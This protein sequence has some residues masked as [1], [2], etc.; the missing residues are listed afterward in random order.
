MLSLAACDETV[1]GYDG[2]FQC[3]TFVAG[4]DALVLGPTSRAARAWQTVQSVSRRWSSLANQVEPWQQLR[5]MDD[6][7]KNDLNW[8][9][10]RKEPDDPG[11][12]VWAASSTSREE[13][14]KDKWHSVRAPAVRLCLRAAAA[15]ERARAEGGV[16]LARADARAQV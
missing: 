3:P 15:H 14:K 8:T 16:R 10:L 13:G 12:L 6:W 1:P 2:E 11:Q 5:S 9:V 4:R 7:S